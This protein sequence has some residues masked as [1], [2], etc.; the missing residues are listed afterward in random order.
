MSDPLRKR[1]LEK[2]F[3]YVKASDTDIARTFAR[4][5]REQKAAQ[6]QAVNVKPLRAVKAK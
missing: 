3:R 5:R 2:T 4:I 1:L 6:E